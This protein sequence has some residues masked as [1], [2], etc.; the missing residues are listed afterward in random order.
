ML[1]NLFTEGVLAFN[2]NEQVISDKDEQSYAVTTTGLNHAKGKA[3][4]EKQPQ[5]R[6]CWKV[7]VVGDESTG[8]RT[9]N[10]GDKL[11]F[12][13]LVNGQNV[14]TCHYLCFSTICNLFPSLP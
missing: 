10:Y 4:S 9:V 8:E 2:L 1:Q 7:E 13:S 6:N 5:L 12:V 11:R 14:L 3:K